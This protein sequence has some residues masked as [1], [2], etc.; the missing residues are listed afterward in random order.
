[1]SFVLLQLKIKT[2]SCKIHKVKNYITLMSIQ[3]DHK[4]LFKKCREI[5]NKITKIIV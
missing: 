4:E 5:W 2:F 3:S 1:M